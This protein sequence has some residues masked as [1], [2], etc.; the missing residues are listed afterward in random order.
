MGLLDCVLVPLRLVLSVALVIEGLTDTVV[1]AEPVLVCEILAVVLTLW[2]AVPDSD[3]D[4]EVVH[5]R[6]AVRLPEKLRVHDELGVWVATSGFV[7]VFVR[8]DVEV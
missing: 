3:S 1:E 5:V 6:L 8:L 2:L 4:L 7:T